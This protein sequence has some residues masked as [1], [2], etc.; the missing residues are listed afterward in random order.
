[1]T[2]VFL[3]PPGSGKGTQGKKLATYFQLAYVASGDLVRSAARRADVEPSNSFYA[4]VKDRML[5]G[6]PQPDDVIIAL[7]REH[8]KTLD[9][10]RGIIFD[11]F[12][13]S[14][15][16]AQGLRGLLVEFA[17]PAP[18][19]FYLAID[20]ME[21]V[22]RIANR[23]FCMKCGSAYSPQHV[24]HKKGVCSI[25]GERL[26]TRSDDRF[27]VVVRRLDEYKARMTMLRRYYRRRGELVELDGQRS[28]DEIFADILAQVELRHASGSQKN[29]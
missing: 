3:G 25:D 15:G 8:L 14:L 16:Q 27:H 4:R 29:T 12:P 13:L 5:R 22:H 7:M 9:L 11:A 1:M 10:S 6:R 21:S 19:V 26:I 23:K 24:E 2:F 20:D 18:I 17:L 28:V